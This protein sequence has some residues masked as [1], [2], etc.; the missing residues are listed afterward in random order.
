MVLVGGRPV[1]AMPRTSWPLAGVAVATIVRLPTVQASL[2][3]VLVTPNALVV[4]EA[5]TIW[6]PVTLPAPKVH[7]T[8]R[9]STGFPLASKTV[10]VTVS[11]VLQDR[12]PAGPAT[13]T[14]CATWPGYPKA[15]D[16]P[17]LRNSSATAPD[18]ASLC[19]NFISSLL[20]RRPRRS[21]SHPSK[22]A[23]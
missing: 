8:A 12:V 10:A 1:A 4:V 18:A 13:V 15:A 9:L 19:P 17:T 16:A 14:C 11:A 22:D 7:A 6:S 23:I 2:T 21:G 5:V 3:V 20:L